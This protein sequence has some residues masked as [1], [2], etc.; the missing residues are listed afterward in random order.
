MIGTRILKIDPEMAEIIGV[1]VG[2][3]IIFFT[4][5]CP[6]VLHLRLKWAVKGSLKKITILLL[7]FI[8]KRFTPPP[9]Y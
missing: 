9:I 4:P 1:K 8:N 6:F 5:K 2:T 7:T 3:Q